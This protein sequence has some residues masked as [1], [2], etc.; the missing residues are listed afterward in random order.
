MIEI[1][2]NGNDLQYCF[3]ITD[4]DGDLVDVSSLE[5]FVVEVYTDGELILTYQGSSITDNT[6]A[7]PWSA[8]NTLASGQIVI[9]VRYGLPN[10]L[11]DDG[12]ENHSKTYYTNKYLKIFK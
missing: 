7:I 6:L 5:D 9:T 8:L 2:Q 1:L 3:E 4:G 10:Q 12:Y 11:F